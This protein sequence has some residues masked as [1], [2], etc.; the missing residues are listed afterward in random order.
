MSQRSLYA[1]VIG[2][3]TVLLVMALI[4]WDYGKDTPEATKKADQLMSLY[5]RYGLPTPGGGDREQGVEQIA[6]TFG[7]DAA[8]VCEPIANGVDL[9]TLKS[10]LGVGGEFY[11]RATDVDDS[12]LI[13]LVLIVATYCPSELDDVQDFLDGFDFEGDLSDV[14]VNVDEVISQMK[15]EAGKTN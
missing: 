1:I 6:R 9:G 4:S 3:L 7:D 10:R 8:Q 5:E 13:G 12:T 2:I 15:A 11:T 14:D